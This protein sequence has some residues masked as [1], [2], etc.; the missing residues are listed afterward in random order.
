MSNREE[1]EPLNGEKRYNRRDAKGRFTSVPHSKQRSSTKRR[2]VSISHASGRP[3]GTHSYKTGAPD[4][5]YIKRPDDSEPSLADKLIELRQ[6]I[7]A[8]GQ[9]LLSW[10]EINEEVA[11]RRGKTE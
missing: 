8:S 4:D 6:K 7:V 1:I 10:D 2:P 3:V 5:S 11:R 9:P